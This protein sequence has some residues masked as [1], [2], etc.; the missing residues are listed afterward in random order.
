MVCL[1]YSRKF[2][3]VQRFVEM[4]PYPS[5]EIF[6]AFI[7]AERKRD[8]LTT[9][10]LDDGHAPYARVTEEMTLNDVVKQ[11][12]ATMAYSSL[13]VEALAIPKVSRLHAVADEKLAC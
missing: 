6:A 9:P 5:E 8:A 13:Y 10:L 11:A 7:F 3:L 1:P 2:S 12:C 4:S